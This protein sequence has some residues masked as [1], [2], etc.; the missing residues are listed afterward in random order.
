MAQDTNEVPS[1]MINEEAV[2]TMYK[3][4]YYSLYAKSS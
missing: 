4:G 2:C 1:K 3:K